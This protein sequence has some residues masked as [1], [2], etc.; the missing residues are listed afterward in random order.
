[1]E[2]TFMNKH[3]MSVFGML[4]K[5]KSMMMAALPVV[6]VSMA[7]MTSDANALSC[8]GTI[9]FKAPDS[10]TTA[11]LVGGGQFAPMTKNADGWFQIEASTAA[12]GNTFRFSKANTY[13]PT[14]WVAIDGYDVTTEVK[15]EFNCSDL[16][17]QMY[18]SENPLALGT[19]YY[20][21]FQA[22]AKYLY[23]MV[24][25]T[26]DWIW[27]TP[28]VSGDG[29]ITGKEMTPVAGHCGWYMAV[30]DQASLP[31]DAIIYSK[32]NPAVT[33]GAG[34]LTLG[35][36]L[37]DAQPEAYFVA[38]EGQIYPTMPTVNGS[39]ASNGATTLYVLL[40]EDK[41]WQSTTPLLTADNGL[42]SQ[43]LQ[44]APNKCGWHMI[45]WSKGAEPPAEAFI[46]RGTAKLEDSHFGAAGIDDDAPIPL[47][48][49]FVDRRASELYF[50]PD[51][52]DWIDDESMG[53]YGTDPGV[54]G[55]CSFKLAAVIYDTDGSVNPLFTE[56]GNDVG[57]GACTGVRHGIV[58]T[59]LDPITKKPV[60]NA[61]NANAVACF[62]DATNF[63]TLFNYTQG[64]NEVQCYDMNFKHYG[65][66]P[67]WGFDSDSA[68]TNGLLGGFYPVEETSDATV[69]TSLS[70]VA[71]PMCRTK[72]VAQGPVPVTTTYMNTIDKFC[73]TPGWFGGVD[74]D[75][76][77]NPTMSFFNGDNPGGFWDWGFDDYKK[78]TG[79]Q[80]AARWNGDRA[81]LPTFMRNQHFCFESHA[82][83]TYSEDQEFTFRGDDDIWVFIGGKLAVDNGGAHLAAPGHVVL[84]NLNTTYGP[85]FLV[86]GQDYALDIFF[87]DRRTTMSNVIIKTNMFIKQTSGLD[88]SA[89]KDADGSTRYDICYDKSGD[90]DCA[91]V[92]LGAVGGNSS[93]NIH[94]CGANISK[95]GSL[96][97]SI[98]TRA[99]SPVATLTAGQDGNQYGGINLK[100]PFAPK[101]DVSKMS[102]LP[103]GSYRLVIDFCDTQGACDEK[104]R[105]YINFRIK[106][107]LDVV[108]RTVGYNPGKGD[109][110]SKFYAAGTKWEYVDKAMAGTRVPVYISAVTESDIDPL[111]GVGQ[112]YTLTLSEGMVA[113]AAKTGDAVVTFPREID[114]TG[115]DTV[116]IYQSLAGMTAAV[117]VKTVKLKTEAKI[118]FHVPRLEFATP[119]SYDD[120]GNVS[121][122]FHPVTADPDTL[123]GEEY[124]H[125]VGSD[126]DFYL[127]VVNPIT[128]EICKDCSFNL[129][130]SDASNRV[131][132]SVGA[133]VDGMA[134]VTVT[135]KVEYMAEPA[136]I[137]VSADDKPDM[138]FV[139]Y[140][141]LRFRKP[142]VPYPMLVD[143]FDA[144]GKAIDGLAI[145]APYY[146]A[147]QEYLDGRGDSLYIVYDRA[148]QPNPETKDYKDSLPDFICLNWD[149]DHLTSNDF[150]TA[151]ASTVKRDTAV[152]CSYIIGKEEIINA[153][154]NRK[155]DSVLIFAVKDTAFSVA[156][157]TAGV[158]KVLNYATFNDRGKISKMHFDKDVTDRMA[159]VIVNARVDNFSDALN[160]LTV[161]FSEP[162]K[163]L[164]ET[165]KSAP[166]TFYMNSA[167]EVTEDKRYASPSGTAAPSGLMTNRVSLLYD[168]T[169]PST[170]PTPRLGDYIRL[171]ADS[172]I[173][174]DTADISADVARPAADSTMHW[175]SPT[176]YKSTA[177]LPSPWVTVV[178]DYSVEVYS[179]NFAVMNGEISKDTKV[180]EVYTI[181]TTMGKEEVMGLYPNT[182][183]FIVKSDM[184]SFM[185]KDSVTEKFFNEH[186][187]ALRDVYFEYEVK[188][189]T[190]LGAYVAGDDARIYCVDEINKQKYG[191]EFFGGKDCR[192]NQQN[193]YIAW[194]MVSDNKR[195]VGTGA[196]IAKLT[197][198]VKLATL[199][200]AK[201]SKTDETNV[202]GAKRGKGLVK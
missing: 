121:A 145:P 87:C 127:L 31:A 45:S 51:E 5:L 163:L 39:C 176:D 192:T 143:M 83:F 61:S 110:V 152:Q 21:K 144:H 42:T 85:N 6:A 18:V 155:A 199:G 158:G 14:S 52:A 137:V 26:A 193:F 33:F 114:S 79:N 78:R 1:M 29:G 95:Y 101:I 73:N 157:K 99:G 63:N 126:A 178:G 4:S 55:T 30:W 106:G 80:S 49:L 182:L 167:S 35:A 159:P 119:A 164:D 86:P 8:S 172:W 77:T 161:T 177:R 153:H 88:A 125:W 194:N 173:W 191:K 201:G 65:D 92:A 76:L 28:M 100:D 171:R 20:G 132:G 54:T 90:G 43:A 46:F 185:S 129:S 16:D 24:P 122:W 188:Y 135:S 19:T 53:W 190:N 175:N 109:E 120:K 32:K 147:T 104:A 66:D 71:C 136:Y 108:S 91:S 70:P 148:F 94:E 40:P 162:V 179:V 44:P 62:Q 117:E 183:G 170:N 197:S 93:G 59:D 154:K 169:H 41:E 50:I 124:Y 184:N 140:T 64:K 23:L 2:K 141:N 3:K 56:D 151:G 149:E 10:W 47:K 17:G 195:L 68:V 7:S 25:Q 67:R 142:P 166:F 84:K 11:Y 146:S 37:S 189:F 160:R 168:K 165:L 116:W 134:V 113:Y 22:D 112:K 15:S 200:K 181:P 131:T 107:N 111:S 81:A 58:M 75:R 123:D 82:S 130:I 138:M 105:T 57:F 187:D 103:P 115:V 128:N 89:V 69:V 97:Y 60:F 202:W 139:K 38:D 12:Q 9:Y 96:K 72:R 150:F 174:S 48:Q 198:F 156:A 102:G 13:Y 34:M 27:S 196:Y 133:F 180:S 98:M 118:E 186:P 74:C 36:I